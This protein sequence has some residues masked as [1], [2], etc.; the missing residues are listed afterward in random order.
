MDSSDGEI[1]DDFSDISEEDY[2]D[3]IASK[4][5]KRKL[6][7]ELL[8]QIEIEA[9]D[10]YAKENRYENHRNRQ[11]T[12]TSRGTFRKEKSRKPQNEIRN[13]AYR[14]SSIFSVGYT[15][16]KRKRQRR[17][18]K[19]SKIKTPPPV[20]YLSSPESPESIVEVK[21]S[22][23]DEELL[24]RLQ[25]LT[26]KK[27]VKSLIEP[28]PKVETIEI[29]QTSPTEPALQLNNNEEELLRIAALRSAILKKK[30]HFRKRKQLRKLENERPYS[31]TDN[32]EAINDVAMDLSNS[33]LGSP[34]HTSCDINEEVDMDIS[35]SPSEVQ[36]NLEECD[37]EIVYSPQPKQEIMIEENEEELALRSMLLS[38][39]NIKK[40]KSEE[41]ITERISESE[42]QEISAPA[43]PQLDITNL[44]MAVERLKQQKQ[45]VPT[46]VSN[47]SGKSGT[48]TIK[49]I[50]EEQK[51]KKLI[52]DTHINDA[53]NDDD[54][55]EL[56]KSSDFNELEID[57]NKIITLIEIKDEQI[58]KEEILE[59]S[60]TSLIDK[61]STSQ[62]PQNNNANNN[63]DSALDKVSLTIEPSD[64]S[65]STIT[66]TKNIPLLPEKK[67]ENRLVTSLEFVIR[68]VTPL[69]ISLSVDSSED[70]YDKKVKKTIRK[71]N[72]ASKSSAPD[73]QTNLD[74]FL[75]NIRSQQELSQVNKTTSKSSAS[76]S[77]ENSQIS[78][79]TSAVK[80][81]PISSQVEYEKLLQ[82]MKILQEAKEQKQKAGTLKRTKSSSDQSN[83]SQNSNSSNSNKNQQQ[84]PEDQQKIV[85]KEL[86]NK[87]TKIDDTIGKIPLL[88]E[89][90]RLRLI[91]KTENNY[92]NHSKNLLEST[93]NNIK[94][95]DENSLDYRRKDNFESKIVEL[96]KSLN[97]YKNYLRI[98]NTRI[99]SNT[100]KIVQSQ[101]EM[102]KLR[103][104]QFKFGQICK[105]VG[106]TVCGN[107]Y[108]LPDCE[109]TKIEYNFLKISEKTELIQKV[110]PED[111]AYVSKQ[112]KL[113]ADK[114][115][116][117][118]P[119]L[120]ISKEI[121]A[122]KNAQVE[123]SQTKIDENANNSKRVIIRSVSQLIASCENDDNETE[124][125]EKSE[126]NV[127][128]EQSKAPEVH[129]NVKRVLEN[130]ESTV[131]KKK[132][133][134]YESPLEF[135]KL[136]DISNRKS[137]NQ[138]ICPYSMEGTCND[139]DCKYFHL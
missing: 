47:K 33:P 70:E 105:K 65:F 87:S 49:M 139:S 101:R 38:S 5:E 124:E 25:A 51:N 74:N 133:K 126:V 8:N 95:L 48:K 131:T 77:K 1:K 136:P 92:L 111:Q 22:E 112:L 21:E 31:P 34:F 83:P 19:Y 94:L 7:L 121:E 127:E 88:D 37:M 66:D 118:V 89:A 91:E 14:A 35:N 50:L 98:V 41:D 57:D 26:S 17:R 16:P 43:S 58:A 110:V 69:I 119:K 99:K 134:H 108:H 102:I 115:K 61:I 68:P 54:E 109:T 114:V 117:F 128:D 113:L 106:E 56:V 15:L 71:V 32:F 24:L 125:H 18:R 80:H 52:K 130:M 116:E 62:S 60:E 6:E 44:K 55:N 67:I 138:I 28:S 79:K 63:D 36:E 78:P 40:L 104:H 123:D 42:M 135:L 39:I 4:I 75:K 97:K 85:A 84:Q 137:V 103:N 100:P 45:H 29:P 13:R 27:E 120:E 90:A 10:D 129:R 59:H 53:P 64:S 30:D 93:E 81:L 9:Y 23:S 82:K 20:V 86:E 73:F 46:L 132:M 107:S 11:N 122:T 76:S 2:F 3:S 12:S 72:H 96:E